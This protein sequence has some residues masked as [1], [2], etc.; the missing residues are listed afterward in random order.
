[1]S[2]TRGKHAEIQEALLDH[3]QRDQTLTLINE[4]DIT[5]IMKRAGIHNTNN[6]TERTVT[7][8]QTVNESRYGAAH[9]LNKTQGL[10]RSGV[11]PPDATELQHDEV[12]PAH[13]L[14]DF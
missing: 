13:K 14:I 10:N 9:D 4:Q 7:F 6:R 8:D 11:L 3:T 5:A 2:N 12:P 1:M